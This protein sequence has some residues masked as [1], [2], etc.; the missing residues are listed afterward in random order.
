MGYVRRRGRKERG[1]GG[2]CIGFDF[3]APTISGG[4]L[5]SGDQSRSVEDMTPGPGASSS[6]KGRRRFGLLC[7][8]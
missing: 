4:V 2:L 3:P 8:C 1:F 6:P 5:C 7:V